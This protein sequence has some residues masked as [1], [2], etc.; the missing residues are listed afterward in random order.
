[1]GAGF[2]NDLTD[3]YAEYFAGEVDLERTWAALDGAQVVGTLRSF[4]TELTVP[5]P[6]GVTAAA[7]TNVTVSPTHRRNGLLTQM[8]TADLAASADRGEPVGILIASE[9]PIYGRF[10]YGPAVE[11]AAYLID[12]GAARFRHPSVGSV[13]RV[14][15]SELR[16]QAPEIYERFRREQPGAIQRSERWWDRT[17][18]QVEVPGEP[19]PTSYA[20]VYRSAEGELEGYLRYRGKQN[21]DNFRPQ[22]TLIVED[23]CAATAGAYQRLWQY[24]CDVDLMT[25]V[26]TATRSV[27]EALPLLLVDGR[28]VQQTGRHDFVWVR[29]LDVAAALEGRR[30]EVGGRLVIDVPD[31][32]GI[33]QG[34]YVLEAGP[35][36]AKC[37]RTDRAPDLTVPVDVL[38]SIYLGGMRLYPLAQA[39]RIH[40]QRAGALAEADAMFSSLRPPWCNTWF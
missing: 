30:Y 36:G 27:Q 20:A 1:M 24:C 40:E 39:G 38:G 28:A 31:P 21:W 10:G 37:E 23:L 17:L 32:L 11:G 2:F 3:E 22:G 4:E 33:V 13:E 14:E 7:L 8:I 26:E 6:R 15:L 35:D 34:R 18:R 9:Y 25:T 19:P 5:G 12:K 29:V 16:R